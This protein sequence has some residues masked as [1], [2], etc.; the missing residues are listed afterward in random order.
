MMQPPQPINQP[1]PPKD[2]GNKGT[3]ELPFPTLQ[4]KHMTEDMVQEVAEF[5][6]RKGE[7]R[8]IKKQSLMK[9]L[10]T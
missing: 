1:T 5:I 3:T 10:V 6:A 7:K 8:E 2:E 4:S 9:R